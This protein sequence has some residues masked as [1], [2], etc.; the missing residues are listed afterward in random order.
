METLCYFYHPDHLGSTSWVTDS[1]KNGVQYCEYLPYGEPFIDQRSTTWS[2]RYTFSGKE[3][4]SETGYSYFGARYYHSDLSIWLSVDPMAEERPSLSPYSYCQNNP[5]IRTDPT[6]ALD[7]IPP[8]DGSG[9]WI[10]EPGDGYWK[11]SQQSGISLEDAKNAVITSNQNRGQ[12]RTSEIMVYPGDVVNIS[13][14]QNETNTTNTLNYQMR[15]PASG[16]CESVSLVGTLIDVFI[17]E[18]IQDGLEY[19]GM[20]ENAA[21]WTSAGITIAGSI[22]LAKKISGGKKSSWNYGAFKSEA[23]WTSQF[24]ERGWTPK[25]V[26][27]AITKGKSFESI[28]KVNPANR[29][30][31]FVHPK[32]GQSVVID[33]T[34]RELLHVGAPGYKY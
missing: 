5:I 6:G 14:P 20:G 19:I 28:N 22:M 18:P 3:R 7:W 33:N 30:T 21:Y 16:V 24:S 8:T 4:D 29:A 11:L 31:R 32:T 25:Q 26:T 13:T 1:A 34:T 15:Y 27:E 2:S 12:A 9:N 17:R 23:K 10:A